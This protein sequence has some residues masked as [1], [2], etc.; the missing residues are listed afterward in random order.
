M[1]DKP[2]YIGL[3]NAVALGE[4][5]A[6]V[7]LNCWA[8]VTTDDDVKAMLRTISLREAEHGL[9]FEKRLDE[10]GFG[11]ID[12][13]DPGQA[14][15]LAIASSTELS[16]RE[17]LERLGLC[18]RPT[19]GVADVFDTFFE[20]KD[21]DPVTGG[22]LG[23]YIAEERDTG[24]R[25]AACHA[26]LSAADG[27]ASR[28]AKDKGGDATPPSGKG[29]MQDLSDQLAVTGQQL[30]GLARSIGEAIASAAR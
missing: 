4:R 25:F 1:T 15:K 30:V 23:R 2:S 10:L 14:D 11:L 29:T 19:N 27:S 24:R 26:A 20:N 12:N 5:R 9:A 22:L 16:D 8:A 28:T 21:L 13:D 18:K 6:A 3:L 17:K 7:Y